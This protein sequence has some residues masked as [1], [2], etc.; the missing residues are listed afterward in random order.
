SDWYLLGYD[1]ETQGWDP[2]TGKVLLSAFCDEDEEV[3]VIDNTSVNNNEIFTPEILKR[4]FFIAH[5]ADFEARWGGVNNF[6]PMRYGCT[7][8][9]DKRLLS[10]EKGYHFDII[11]TINRRLGYQAVPEWMEK[12]IRNSFAEC[13]FFTDDQIL[14]NAADTILLK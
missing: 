8:V 12:D 4:C 14:Y 11:S 6:L 7:M 13:T 3:L 1:I 5:N 2:L 9:N 10:G